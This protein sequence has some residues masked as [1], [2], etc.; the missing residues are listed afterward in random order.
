MISHGIP[1]H[2]FFAIAQPPSAAKPTVDELEP[3]YKKPVI[4][5]QDP[6]TSKKIS[7]ELQSIWTVTTAELENLNSFCL[8]VYGIESKKLLKVLEKRY[9]EIQE[10]QT[11]RF[12]LLKKL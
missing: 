3:N 5:L 10:K 9:P 2:P 11:V 1:D 6:K 4:E 7:A 12:L 8:L